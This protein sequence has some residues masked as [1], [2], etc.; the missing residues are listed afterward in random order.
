M[1]EKIEIQCHD[2]IL[3]DEWVEY[4]CSECGSNDFVVHEAT[5]G[6]DECEICTE[7]RSVVR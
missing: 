3:N 5:F 1:A 6:F 7:C 4:Y 2:P